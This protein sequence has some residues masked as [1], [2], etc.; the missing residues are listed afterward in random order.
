VSCS[1]S[2][3]ATETYTA[4]ASVAASQTATVTGSFPVSDLA[5]TTINSVTV[6]YKILTADSDPATL[7]AHIAAAINA[8]TTIDSVTGRP[9]NALVAASN[10]GGVITIRAAS[11]SVAFTLGCSV[12]GLRKVLKDVLDFARIKAAISPD[13]DQLLQVLENPN[14]LSSDGVTPELVKLTGWSP[15]SLSALLQHFFGSTRLSSVA[16]IE[17]LALVYDAF[18]L[19]TTSRLSAAALLAGTTNAPTPATVAALQSA[20]RSLYADADWRN[21]IKP[22]SDGMRVKQRDALVAYIL[23]QLGDAYMQTLTTLTTTAD[24]AAGAT[25]LKVASTAGVTGGMGVQA[26]NVPPNAIVQAVAA[27]TVTLSA[28]LSAGLPSGSSVVFVPTTSVNIST[29]DNLFE[30]FLMDVE[31]QPPVETSRIR[32]AL[33][34]VQLFIERV[35]R[36]LEPQVNPTDI[37]GKLWTWMKRYRVWQANREVFLWPENWLYPELRDDQSPL[38]QQMMASLL[39]SDITDDAAASAY[40]DYLSGLELVAKLEPCGLYYVPATGDSDEA[41]YVVARTAGAHRKHYF[42]QLQY[43]NWTPWTEI[44]IDCEDMPVTPIVWNGRLMLFWLKVTKS[45]TPQSASGDSP[46]NGGRH[47]S[48][49]I[50]NMSLDDFQSFGQASAGKQKTSNVN[51]SAVLSWSEYYNGKWQPQKSSDVNRPTF[52]G[53][54]DTDGPYS[55]DVDRNLLRITPMTVAS[56]FIYFTDWTV[57]NTL[58]SD[59]LLI[60]ITGPSSSGGGFVL[61]NTHSLPVRWED[62][63]VQGVDQFGFVGSAPLSWMVLP[64]NPGRTLQPALPYTGGDASGNFNIS[65]WTFA[66]SPLYWPWTQSNAYQNNILGLTRTPRTVDCAPSTDGWDA[67]FFF[68]D[69]KNVFYVTTTESWISFFNYGLYGLVGNTFV[70]PSIYVPPLA[71][72]VPPVVQPTPPFVTGI[73]AGGGDPA[74]IVHSAAQQG[75]I[76]IAV[77]GATSVTY[78]GTTLYPNGQSTAVIRLRPVVSNTNPSN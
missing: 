65:Y 70:N 10:A 21:V 54:Y 17:N 11:P 58:P 64:S 5:V 42:R 67:P 29:A 33:S 57:Q 53:V 73:V 78:Q 20:L 74:A 71:V 51:V 24:A 26:Y 38:F 61:Y 37:D 62:I 39:Q 32:L 3:G 25:Q 28:P 31:T 75:N 48:D 14:L 47:S 18:A 30:F 72:D 63:S 12:A 19:V 69:R 40:L 45:V 43:G 15:S 7:A 52:I 44:K 46:L 55:F 23:Q 4:G 13:S 66:G 41:S 2:G 49:N 16:S 36:N 60:G 76:R 22:V 77:G 56:E 50:N 8:T 6:Q 68:E 35:L 27:G 1:V 9:L 59:A 34:S